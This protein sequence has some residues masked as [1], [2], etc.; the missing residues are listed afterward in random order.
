MWTGTPWGYAYGWSEWSESGHQVVAK[1]GEQPGANAYIQMYPDDD[2]IIAVL[3]NRR[4]G[5]HIQ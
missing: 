3:S 4:Y 2:I 1:N 5:G